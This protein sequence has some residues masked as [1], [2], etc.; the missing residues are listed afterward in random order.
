MWSNPGAFAPRLPAGKIEAGYLANILLIRDDHACLWPNID[1]L[2]G[3]A[4]ADVAH[5]IDGMLV[6]G[7]WVGEVGNFQRSIL[8]SGV[9][10]VGEEFG[11]STSADYGSMGP[12]QAA[13]RIDS[14]ANMRPAV[15][16]RSMWLR[17]SA[18]S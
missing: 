17:R 12:G 4:Y 2:R 11:V 3:L 13:E 9:Y 5:A 7:K 15:A 18:E 16:C 1:P 10:K 14:F 8:E 6:A